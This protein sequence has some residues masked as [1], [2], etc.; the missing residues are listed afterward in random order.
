MNEFTRKMKSSLSADR[1]S[2]KKNKSRGAKLVLLLV[3][4][5]VFAFI[6]ICVRIH[7]NSQIEKMNQEAA[8]LDSEIEQTRY[9]IQNARNRKDELCSL[10]HIRRQIV[11]FNLPL[12]PR[13]PQQLSYLRVRKP[14][15]R[16]TSA[17][18]TNV[19]SS[20]QLASVK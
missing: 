11:R 7:F 2:R 4:V 13:E 16:Q 1:V 5:F 6:M 17:A 18:V 12:S 20:R 19:E 10:N 14:V 3:P 15:S 9:N 8:R